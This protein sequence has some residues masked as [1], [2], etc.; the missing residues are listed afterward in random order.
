MPTFRVTKKLAT[1]LKVKLSKDR[2]ADVNLEHEWFADLFHVERKKCV[3]W[4]HRTTL[5][6]FVRPAVT[7]AELREHAAL[8]RYEYFT[9]QA[10][11]ALPETLLMRFDVGGEDL[12]AA[13]ADRGVVGSMLD[14]RK[15]F[16]IMVHL[17]GGLH[18]ADVRGVNAQLNQS[19]M[20]RLGLD[21]ALRRIRKIAPDLR[22]V[23]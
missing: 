19:P 7:A 15:M 3:I 12:Y 20:S 8:F 14:Y 18:H 10:S 6:T 13:T 16:E 17:D 5:L 21:S 22:V 11:L 2:P 1:A 23:H 9:T 4:V